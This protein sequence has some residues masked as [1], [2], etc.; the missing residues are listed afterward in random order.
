MPG[1]SAVPSIVCVL[2]APAR[3]AARPSGAGGRATADLGRAPREAL[4]ARPC[5]AGTRGPPGRAPRAGALLAGA[6]AGARGVRAPEPR[7]VLARGLLARAR[8]VA[9]QASRPGRARACLAVGEDADVVAVER[10]GHQR[11]HVL[12]HLRLAGA[13]REGAVEVE[14]LRAEQP[15]AGLSAL[16][17]AVRLVLEVRAADMRTG[18]CSIGDSAAAALGHA[19]LGRFRACS[20]CMRHLAASRHVSS[21]C[22]SHAPAR[23]KHARCCLC[24]ASSARGP[25]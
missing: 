10:A 18:A 1:S 21:P 12:E 7:R 2:P 13:G 23:S 4:P 3:R 14:R 16:P 20:V 9:G 8:L 6:V 5:S 11:R 24:P 25:R 22:A 19:A 17:T 15:H